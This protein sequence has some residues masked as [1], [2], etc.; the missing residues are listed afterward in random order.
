[1]ARRALISL[2][3]TTSL[4]SRSSLWYLLMGIMRRHAHLIRAGGW[5]EPRAQ[6][7]NFHFRYQVYCSGHGRHCTPLHRNQQI[8]AVTRLMRHQLLVTVS[9]LITQSASLESGGAAAVRWHQTRA[10]PG[11]CK[12]RVPRRAAV[13]LSGDGDG[14]LPSSGSSWWRLDDRASNEGS[15]KGASP[16]WKCLLALSHLRH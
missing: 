11:W 13:S 4:S 3:Y 14:D 15:R 10:G 1:M 16:G 12:P 9:D 2:Q 8:V 7:D 5:D 6:Q